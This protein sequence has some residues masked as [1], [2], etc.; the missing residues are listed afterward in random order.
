M[1]GA[2]AYQPKHR[3]GAGACP[4]EA[5]RSGHAPDH[6]WLL[7]AAVGLE[8]ADIGPQVVDLL[9][10]LDA[11]EEHLGAL[12]HPARILDIFLELGLAPGD[13]RILVGVAVIVAGGRPRLA[14]V[15][16]VEL[17]TNAVLGA[18]ADL[19]A[20]HALLENGFAGF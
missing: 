7:L 1:I 8:L 4:G 17:R 20:G 9:V 13:A 3:I 11:G 6:T 12:N 10:V 15:E 14:A 19:V 2:V 18:L 16:A 5:R